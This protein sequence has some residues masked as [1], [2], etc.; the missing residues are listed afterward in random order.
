MGQMNL[1]KGEKELQVFTDWMEARN[2]DSWEE[3]LM[4]NLWRINSSLEKLIKV[5]GD[6]Q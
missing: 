1:T 4:F 6:K 5:V 3:G 2:L